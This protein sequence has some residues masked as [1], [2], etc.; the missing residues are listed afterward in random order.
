MR[1]SGVQHNRATRAT[2]PDE[3]CGRAK[4]DWPCSGAG[5]V[6]LGKQPPPCHSEPGSPWA[7][8]E[9]VRRQR[10][11]E[12][13]RLGL[14][15]CFLPVREKRASGQSARARERARRRRGCS[16]TST[17]A[18]RRCDWRASLGRR[19]AARRAPP[20]PARSSHDN[21]VQTGRRG[22]DEM[23]HPTF[24]PSTGRGG[25]GKAP[26]L[27][28]LPSNAVSGESIVPQERRERTTW[29]RW[30]N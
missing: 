6:A 26:F 13:R 17:R 18:R 8:G 15:E 29:R 22:W 20:L 25:L 1:P 9:R 7:A 30:G 11:G 3:G 2:P 21:P 27:H 24:P 14:V 19:R 5:P 23:Y 12:P 28:G 10:S 4:S 16:S